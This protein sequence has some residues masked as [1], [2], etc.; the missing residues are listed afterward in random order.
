MGTF[1]TYFFEERLPT[2]AER[3]TKAQLVAA[4]AQAMTRS[5]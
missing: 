2:Q 5:R 3:Q 4:A 1:G